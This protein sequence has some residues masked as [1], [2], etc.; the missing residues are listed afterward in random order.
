MLY[1]PDL[2]MLMHCFLKSFDRFRINFE[3]L[4]VVVLSFYRLMNYT[5]TVK[6]LYTLS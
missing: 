5:T 2:I 4:Y 3:K 1:V 6:P